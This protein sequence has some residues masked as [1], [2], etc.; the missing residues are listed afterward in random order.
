MCLLMQIASRTASMTSR[1]RH[2]KARDAHMRDACFA[3]SI[4]ASPVPRNAEART[5]DRTIQRGNIAMAAATRTRREDEA[6]DEAHTVV[7]GESDEQLP[8][9]AS[10]QLASRQLLEVMAELR[11]PALSSESVAALHNR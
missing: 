5:Q 1:Q 6:N 8:A 7:A 3:Q 10:S 4:H 9:A 11:I 2:T